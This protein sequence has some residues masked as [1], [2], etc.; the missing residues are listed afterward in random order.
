MQLQEFLG[1]LLHLDLIVQ[2]QA[3]NQAGQVDVQADLAGRRQLDVQR[4]LNL[5]HDVVDV[6]QHLLRV[7]DRQMVDDVVQSE[8]L[9]DV[10]AEQGDLLLAE[11]LL[12][13]LPQLVDAAGHDQILDGDELDVRHIRIHGADDE[14]HVVLLEDGVLLAVL[15]QLLVVIGDDVGVNRAGQTLL[16]QVHDLLRGADAG[17]ADRQDRALPGAVVDELVLGRAAFRAG[18]LQR[19]LQAGALADRLAQQNRHL[20]ADVVDDADV[21]VLGALDAAVDLFQGT[22]VHQQQ[23]AVELALHLQEAVQL[24]DDL[25]HAHVQLH[26]DRVKHA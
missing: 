15:G 19:L 17:G 21:D 13:Q 5:A 11:K 8:V 23:E 9:D 18:L 24:D 16:K 4:L 3:L 12:H 25:V 6:L 2:D 1:V 14:R 7:Q 10:V 20:R 22:H 26:V